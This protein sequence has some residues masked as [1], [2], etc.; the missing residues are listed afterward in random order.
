[1]MD[2][3]ALLMAAK[4]ANAVYVE[5]DGPSQAAF[6]QLGDRWLGQFRNATHQAVLSTDPT[7]QVWLSI[8]GTR[9]SQF[10]LADVIE[11]ASLEP[12]VVVAGKVTQG[13]VYRMAEVWNWVAQIVP[14]DRT[15][16]VTGH[17]LGG[18]RTHLTP[19]FL[20]AVRIQSIYS[21]EAPKFCNGAYYDTYKDLFQAKMICVLNGR[22]SWAAWPWVDM[23]WQDRPRQDHLWLNNGSFQMIDPKNWPGLGKMSDHSMDTVEANIAQLVANHSPVAI[24]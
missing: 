5:G 6:V 15:I 3:H 21:F 11:D 18:A 16:A 9:V 2:W 12:Q 7:G 14:K 20:D 22:D 24:P 4:R 8:S 13:V 17:S 10:E 19:L 23:R 1:M